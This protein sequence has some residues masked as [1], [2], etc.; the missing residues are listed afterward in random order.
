MSIPA[1]NS[2]AYL[3]WLLN[4]LM[5]QASYQTQDIL[6]TLSQIQASEKAL[7]TNVTSDQTSQNVL[8]TG[9]ALNIDYQNTENKSKNTLDNIAG[10]FGAILTY[11]QL[12]YHLYAEN[13]NQVNAALQATST[14]NTK[15]P[16]H[17]NP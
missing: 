8:S 15:E 16:V 9:A 6:A 1:A 17:V 2:D 11:M 13:P 3:Q 14:G 4:Q 10:S 5:Q 7:L 12:A